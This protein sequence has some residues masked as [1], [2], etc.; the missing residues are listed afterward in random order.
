[1]Y[2]TVQ[3]LR[4]EGI[5]EAQASDARLEALIEEA[6]RITA[7]DIEPTTDLNGTEEFKRKIARVLTRRT[8]ASAADR[9]RFSN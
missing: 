1:M 7:E 2:A 5:T 8:I 9:A 6:A 4:D 3:D